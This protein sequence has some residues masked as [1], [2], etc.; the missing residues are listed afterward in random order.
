MSIKRSQYEF[1]QREAIRLLSIANIAITEEEKREIEVCD[2]GLSNLNEEGMQILVYINSDRYCAKE[3]ILFP[4]QTCP[5]HLHPPILNECG[6]QET[7]RCRWGKLLVYI[8]GDPNNAN[9]QA[10]IPEKNKKYYTARKEIIL[11]PG[12]QYTIL[13][14]TPH[15]FQSGPEGAIFSEFSSKSV[16]EKDV[17]TNPNI[18]RFTKIIE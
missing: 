17:F 9:I 18:Y 14:N 7:F 11:K 3:M 8:P 13:P 16:S 2:Y 10:I 1:A 15:W 6:K 4:R 12:E 5:E